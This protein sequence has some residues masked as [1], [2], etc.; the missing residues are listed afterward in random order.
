MSN[1]VHPP[2]S[3]PWRAPPPLA[4]EA[5]NM[6]SARSGVV[7]EEVLPAAGAPHERRR[8]DEEARRPRRPA[9]ELV[10][11]GGDALVVL[12][13]EVDVLVFVPG[14]AAPER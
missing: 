4:L 11:D 10:R 1:R 7:G 3:S 12:E 5:A 8:E 9:V 13:A 14:P 2:G 6:S